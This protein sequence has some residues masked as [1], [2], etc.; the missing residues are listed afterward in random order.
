MCYCQY[1]KKQSTFVCVFILHPATLLNS[2][3]I[4][5]RHFLWVPWNIPPRYH[6]QQ[7]HLY[8]FLSDLCAFYSLSHLAA[9]LGASCPEASENSKTCS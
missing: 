8:F 1:I 5:R 9:P 7:W 4:S 3:T 2:F 6:H